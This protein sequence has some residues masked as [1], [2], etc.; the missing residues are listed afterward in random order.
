MKI[1]YNNFNTGLELKLKQVV[2][3]CLNN[4]VPGNFVLNESPEE[5]KN[6][7]NNEITRF[8]KMVKSKQNYVVG[9]QFGDGE[10][11][12]ELKEVQNTKK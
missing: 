1:N 5:I 9:L 8:L 6:Y 11:D 4:L 10:V 12:V 7:I 3:K 2:G